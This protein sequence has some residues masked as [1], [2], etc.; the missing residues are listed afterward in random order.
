MI[1]WTNAF[2]LGACDVRIY[3]GGPSLIEPFDYT[4]YAIT[5]D[6]TGGVVTVNDGDG[7]VSHIEV[8]PSYDT[9]SRHVR[10][11]GMTPNYGRA[12]TWNPDGVTFDQQNETHQQTISNVG[13]IASPD[14]AEFL[15]PGDWASISLNTRR[16]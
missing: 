7:V 9:A 5:V 15:S 3:D 12:S 11:I 13:G 4:N 2:N 1:N 6:T 16:A 14:P 8:V 10:A